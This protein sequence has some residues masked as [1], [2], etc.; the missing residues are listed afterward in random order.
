MAQ[1]ADS[2]NNG[3]MKIRVTL[4]VL[5]SL[6]CAQA[7][8]KASTTYSFGSP[9]QVQVSFATNAYTAGVWTENYTGSLANTTEQI[10]CV[11]G[12]T[13][14][15]EQNTCGNPGPG[16]SAHISVDTTGGQPGNAPGALTNYLE[17]DGDPTWGAPVSTEMTGLT[18][19]DAYTLTFYQASNEEDGSKKAYV[20]QWLVYAIPNATQGVYMCPESYCTTMANPDPNDLIYTSDGMN[21]A[22]GVSTP[23]VQETTYFT[24]TSATEVLEFVTEA[25]GSA[26]FAPPLLDLAL[27]T[28][29]QGTP[30]AGTWV[31]T[32][33]GLGAVFAATRLRRRNS[34]AYKRVLGK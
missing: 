15:D 27:V 30:E 16:N 32:L 10:V 34:T 20:D 23:W 3:H 9:T 17:I 8:M 11:V 2:T 28:T 18:P 14:A 22:G 4:V 6:L 33:A 19:G 29:T 12:L 21:N 26:G 7:T 1:T 24:A 13:V 5:V 25:T 31:L